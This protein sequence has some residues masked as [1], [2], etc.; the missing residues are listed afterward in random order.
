MDIDCFNVVVRMLTY[1][2][3]GFLWLEDKYHYIEPAVLCNFI[4]LLSIAI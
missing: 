3:E 2:N 1:N 4:L